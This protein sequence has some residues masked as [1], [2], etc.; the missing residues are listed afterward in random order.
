MPEFLPYI[1]LCLRRIPASASGVAVQS[2]G[3]VQSSA[4]SCLSDQYHI[5]THYLLIAMDLD[6]L[7]IV[8]ER[9]ENSQVALSCLSS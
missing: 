3:T 6:Y 8:P 9:N 5:F 4:V 2:M 1:R 7:Y